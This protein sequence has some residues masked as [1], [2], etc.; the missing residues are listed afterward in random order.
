ML[1]IHIPLVVKVVYASDQVEHACSIV[2]VKL[3]GLFDDGNTDKTLALIGAICDDKGCFGH[4]SK[5]MNALMDFIQ[6]PAGFL[7]C[8]LALLAFFCKAFRMYT[9]YTNP[10]QTMHLHF[11]F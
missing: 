3:E 1:W 8:F 11:Y 6:V 10:L 2:Q 4:L 5:G 9:V 7:L